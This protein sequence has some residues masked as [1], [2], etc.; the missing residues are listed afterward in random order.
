MKIIA[1]IPAKSTSQRIQN[2]NIADLAGHPLMAYSIASALKA[3]V[4]CK[5]VVSTDSKRYQEIAIKYGAYVPWL[6]P[7]CYATP[8][9][10]DI[11]WVFPL[12][13]LL[14]EDFH[15]D[16][17]AILRPTSPFRSAEMICKAWYE[18]KQ[19]SVDS[20]RAV[21]P[22]SQHPG[23]M[24]KVYNN[25]LLPL[26]PV[27]MEK[28]A[29]PWHSSQSQYLPKVYVQNASLEIAWTKMMF[30]TRT[31][32]GATVMPFYTKGYDGFD[33]N[34]AW[35]LVRARYLAKHGH[36]KLPRIDNG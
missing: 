36:A 21:E 14:W 1:L 28:G 33:I 18:F 6:R 35:D 3:D 20:L 11:D 17:F 8:T 10:P 19:E 32:A 30:E 7:E 29:T 9:S 31:I 15:P 24:W 16:A 5:V 22:A 13:Q 23:K 12:M 25:R 34:D 26:I 4:F 27:S 2:K